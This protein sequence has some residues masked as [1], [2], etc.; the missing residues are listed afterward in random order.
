MRAIAILAAS[1][2]T[3]FLLAQEARYGVAVPMTFSAQALHTHRA[4]PAGAGSPLAGGLR[5]MLYPSVKL[6]EHWF[7]YGA[8][9][10]NRT[11]YFFEEAGSAARETEASVVQAYI[12]YSRV[13][14]DRAITVKAGQL[15]SAFGAFPLR[16]DDMRNS[17]IDVPLGYGEYYVPVSLYGI[18][19]AE[20]DLVYKQIDARL[21]FTN[22]SPNNPRKLWQSDQYGTW[23]T[24][25]GVAIRQGLRVGASMYRGPYLDRSHRFFRANEAPPKTLPALGYGIDVQA[26]KGRWTVSGEAQRFQMAY[27]AAPYF[28]TSIAY[29]EAKYTLSPRW[30]LAGRSGSR[31]RTSNL[32]R[33]DRWEAVAG[34]RPAARHLIKFGYEAVRSKSSPGTRDNI[35]AIQYVVQI[36]PPSWAIR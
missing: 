2:L 31:W 20:V 7:G 18:P 12:G 28:F 27:R 11:P 24:G 22:S 19:G 34:F 26:A 21:Q 5:A 33:D 13:A 15:T 29:A 4:A 14:K 10:V 30:Y 35:A 3:P 1:L 6:G 16:Y 25:A 36:Q 23:T 9:Q 32:G 8:V 17:L